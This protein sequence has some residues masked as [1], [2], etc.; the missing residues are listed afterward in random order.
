MI[1]T[2]TTIPPRMKYLPGF[3]ANLARQ[4]HRPDGVE[5]YVPYSYRRFPGQIPSLPR[6]P[7][8]VTVVRIEEDYGP[9]T[10]IL[11]AVRKWQGQDIDILFCDDDRLYDRDWAAR[12]AEARATYPDYAICEKGLPLSRM[13]LTDNAMQNPDRPPPVP[14]MFSP[15]RRLAWR[16]GFGVLF[17]NRKAYTSPGYVD[18]MEGFCGCLVKP[19]W[20]DEEVFDIPPVLWTVDDVWLSG[21]LARRGITIRTTDKPLISAPFRVSS[22]NHPLYTHVEEGADRFEA[23]AACMRYFQKTYGVWLPR[24]QAA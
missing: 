12:F 9:A 15:L 11:P 1:I 16:Y 17:P 19:D 20:F 13:G 22:E 10:K 4:R 18:V 5:L 6:L 24:D 3:F 21:H 14:A 23:N 7:S 2:C 8:W